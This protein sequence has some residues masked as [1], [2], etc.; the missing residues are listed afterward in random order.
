MANFLKGYKTYII[1]ALVVLIGVVNLLT[2][3]VSWSQFISSPDLLVILNGL[4][5][6][7]LRAAVQKN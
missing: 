1:A 6:G 7:T 3:D 4:G 2:G 5:L